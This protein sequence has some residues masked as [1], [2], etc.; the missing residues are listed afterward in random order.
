MLTAF[1]VFLLFTNILSIASQIL[2]PEKSYEIQVR[3]L[4][5]KLDKYKKGDNPFH[6]EILTSIAMIGIIVYLLL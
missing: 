3:N 4:V 5:N 6:T 1:L 2:T